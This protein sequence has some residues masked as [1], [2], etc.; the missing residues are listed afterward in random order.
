M[1]TLVD[2]KVIADGFAIMRGHE[3]SDERGTFR[4]L[5]DIREIRELHPEFS[6]VQVNLS[7]TLNVGAVRGMHFQRPPHTETKIVTC[8][9]GAVLDAAV[10][11]RVGSAGYGTVYTWEL[12]EGSGESVIVG[13]GMA[14][15]FQA[16]TPSALVHYSVDMFYRPDSES[17]VS[18]LDEPLSSVWPMTPTQL[19]RRD[20]QLPSLNEYAA[21]PVFALT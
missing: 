17:G 16:L 10:D 13:P 2:I 11:L 6:V 9:A 12:M 8:V 21:C 18:A 15:G 7:R 5:L 19:S 20:R 3:F 1:F 4:R 14:H